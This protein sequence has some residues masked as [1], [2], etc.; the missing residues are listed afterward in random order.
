[1]RKQPL[2][3]LPAPQGQIDPRF[4]DHE[5]SPQGTE[6]AAAEGTSQ[7]AEMG[8]EVIPAA[9]DDPDKQRIHAK[10]GPAP[11]WLRVLRRV[12]AK[13]ELTAEEEAEQAEM[14]ALKAR[15]KMLETESKLAARRI[16]RRLNDLGFCYRYTDAERKRSFFADRRPIRI[17][18]VRMTDDALYFFLDVQHM[19]PG[20][21]VVDIM[22]E[23]VLNELSLSCERRVVS[24]YSE[25]EGA[26]YIV[27]RASGVMG[28]PGHV[29]LKEVLDR[30]PQTGSKLSI[31][32]GIGVNRNYI[33]RDLR[34]MPH[35][36]VAGTTG[37]GK[38]NMLNVILTTLLQ[39]NQPD[40][41]RMVFIDL[42]GGLEL[43]HYAGV[44]HMLP[45]ERVADGIAT[46]IEEVPYVLYQIIDQAQ[47]RMRLISQAGFSDVIDYNARK[48][49]SKQ[50]P[51]IVI[52]FDEL[53]SLNLL[54]RKVGKEAQNLLTDLGNRGRA[55]GIHIIACTQYPDKQVLNTAIK[56][57]LNAKMA[58]ACST[59]TASQ[60]ILGNGDAKG[61]APV[62]RYI[63]QSGAENVPIQAPL[64][65]KDYREDI[66][67]AIRAG[68]KYEHEE[69]HDVTP[70][71]IMEWSLSTQ[72]GYLRRDRIY[73]TF[74][75][76]G[77][78]RAE[79]DS[80]L[81]SWEEHQYRL[82][83]AYYIVTK[84]SGGR[85]RM[86]LAAENAETVEENSP[87]TGDGREK[88]TPDITTT[89]HI[90]PEETTQDE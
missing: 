23:Q 56:S 47:Q 11:T 49:R 82:N 3:T 37:G 33:Y 53:A 64:F 24:H 77:I 27:E 38:S 14:R 81:Q 13:R 51:R 32:M 1:M 84:P 7:A 30:M 44:P 78:T 58:F 76:R 45:C 5:A 86:L 59:L 17:K 62:G 10:R 74:R 69:G 88:S 52:A 6:V 39:R 48:P 8:G 50:I 18:E 66:L 57:V 29:R 4:V 65:P 61:L 36:L 72:K 16:I 68:T 2:I 80:M 22:Q 85:P 28:I 9:N 70:G 31:P 54:D 75:E 20:V 15:R 83:D 90:K 89:P 34:A 60:V 19:P 79:I 35:L 12:T 46:E 21:R 42:K 67:N 87:T 73:E 26:C 40:L 41:L 71:Q 63:Y 43:K 25:T 55:V